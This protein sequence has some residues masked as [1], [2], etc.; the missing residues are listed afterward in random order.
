MG[1]GWQWLRSWSTDRNRCIGHT[2]VYARQHTSVSVGGEA[3]ARSH[4]FSNIWGLH[5]KLHCAECLKTCDWTFSDVCSKNNVT[6]QYEDICRCLRQLI[7]L[8]PSQLIHQGYRHFPMW[9]RKCPKTPPKEYLKPCTMQFIIFSPYFS[10]SENFCAI[11][12]LCWNGA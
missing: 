3:C 9:N 12:H 11:F 5:T 7:V 2:R 8:K 10:N 4:T 1:N 6:Y